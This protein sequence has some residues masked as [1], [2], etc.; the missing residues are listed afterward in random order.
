[1]NV[2]RL[3]GRALLLI[4]ISTGVAAHT[5]YGQWSVYRETHLLILTH[6]AD[7]ATFDLGTAVAEY[8][9]AALPAS[10]ARVTRAPDMIRV[11]SLIATHQLDVALLHKD[12]AKGLAQGTMSSVYHEPIPLRTLLL[13][14]DYALV[15]HADFDDR[16]AYQVAAAVLTDSDFQPAAV[17]PAAD[18]IPPAHVGVGLWLAGAPLPE[19]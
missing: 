4:V 6:K 14:G 18:A 2:R 15:S 5:P 11:A 1:M 3:V 8:L 10:Q 19:N 7:P 17:A 13:I 9:A 16:H 12:D